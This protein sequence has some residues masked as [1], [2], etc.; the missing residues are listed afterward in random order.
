[1]LR[2]NNNA[3]MYAHWSSRTGVPFSSCAVNQPL[4]RSIN[5]RS[6]YDYRTPL[7]YC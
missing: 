2:S 4:A 7:I 3:S 1:M 5:R 6:T